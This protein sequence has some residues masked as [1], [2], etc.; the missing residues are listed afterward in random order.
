MVPIF[1][2][3]QALNYLQLIPTVLLYVKKFK[4][5]REIVDMLQYNKRLR[6]FFILLMLA[7]DLLMVG[8][9]GACL[10][11]G[12]D[13]LLWR[14]QYYGNDPQFYWLSSNSMYPVDLMNG[15][16]YVQYIYAQSFST[17][18]LSTIAPG[19]FAKNPI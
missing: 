15:P 12:M 1:K 11:V 14:L 18:T 10:F 3:Y 19:P 9:F 16:W 6:I 5:Q 4:C 17:G 13:L 2:N 7:I 8:H